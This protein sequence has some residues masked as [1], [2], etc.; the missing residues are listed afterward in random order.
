MT[1]AHRP[2]SSAILPAWI[3]AFAALGLFMS[4]P[5]F[6]DAISGQVLGAS[7]P[8]VGSTVTLWAAGAGAPTQLA[9]SQTDADG[10]FV[11]NAESRGA[12]LYVIAQGG[13]VA[14]DK[15]TGGNSAIAL[16]SVLGPTPPANVV[17]NEMTTIASV[18]TLNQFLGGTAVR[19]PA[20]SLK[21]AAG[22]IANFVE[23]STGGWG[24]AIQ[25][26]LN[27]NQTNHNG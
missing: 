26:P 17:A 4:A 16:L 18:W 12:D 5:A 22:N 20:L 10:R 21:I 6:A 19:G 11:L 9:R 2:F 8:I 15:T 25:G 7:A 1:R 24:E 14:G 3:G 23:L 13:R 27:S